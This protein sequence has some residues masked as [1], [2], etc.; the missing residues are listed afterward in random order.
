[1]ANQVLPPQELPRTKAMRERRPQGGTKGSSGDP[2]KSIPVARD[3]HSRPPTNSGNGDLEHE[4]RASRVYVFSQD[5]ELQ[6][7]RVYS[8]RGESKLP[9]L[10]EAE[11]TAAKRLVL[12]TGEPTDVRASCVTPG[13]G[14]V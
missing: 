5:A 1:M 9:A 2:G 3:D 13:G 11:V 8:P 7:P 14:T 12:R 6:Q 10:D 4:L